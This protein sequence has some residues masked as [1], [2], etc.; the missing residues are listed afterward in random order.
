MFRLL[1]ETA[2]ELFADDPPLH[3][4]V[5]SLLEQIMIDEVGHVSFC[6]ARLGRM[7]LFVARAVLP[8]MAAS[9][10]SDIPE[11][12]RLVGPDRFRRAV[13]DADLAR[14]A[15]GCHDRPFLL[16]DAR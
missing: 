14:L 9:L 7:G 12:A 4:R 2:R 3:A 13:A 15:E 10:L 1:L 6:R 11:V 8:L 16:E 5:S